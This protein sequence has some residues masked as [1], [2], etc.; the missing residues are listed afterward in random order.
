MVDFHHV[1]KFR[2]T[3]SPADDPLAGRQD[4]RAGLATEIHSLVH[5]GATVERIDPATEAGGDPEGAGKDPG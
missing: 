1:A 2:V 4:G 3:A 5:L